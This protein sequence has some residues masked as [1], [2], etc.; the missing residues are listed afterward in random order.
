MMCPVNY[1]YPK[2]N[3]KGYNKVIAN[4]TQYK[5]LLQIDKKH[6]M[7]RLIKSIKSKYYRIIHI[8]FNK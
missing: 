5:H 8:L 2:C 4:C 7:R 1:D 3:K 6:Q